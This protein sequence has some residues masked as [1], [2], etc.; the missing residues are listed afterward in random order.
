MFSHILIPTDGTEHSKRAAEAGVALAKA[1]GARV[2]GLY[3]EPAPTPVVYKN[4][5]PVRYVSPDEHAAAIERAADRYLGVIEA[6]AA[7]AGV[8]CK[9]IRLT[10]E[11]PAETILDVARRRKCDLIVM[12]SHGHTGLAGLLLGSET[13]KVLTHAKIPV[14]IFR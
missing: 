4:F 2:T 6:A 5:L 3:A 10:S 8:Q 9:T 7:A 13:Q 14:L 12:A 1:V 11:Y